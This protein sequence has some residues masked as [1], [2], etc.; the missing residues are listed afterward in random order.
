M[1][2]E[3]WALVLALETRGSCSLLVGQS[4]L[5]TVQDDQRH[6]RR[7]KC[8]MQKKIFKFSFQ[9]FFQKSTMVQV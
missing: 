4:L 8:D 1:K 5:K 9:Q 6:V 3:A 7:S 2:V